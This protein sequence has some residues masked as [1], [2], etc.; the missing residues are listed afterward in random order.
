MLRY[1]LLLL[2]LATVSNAGWVSKKQFLSIIDYNTAV[3][4]VIAANPDKPEFI[5]FRRYTFGIFKQE[6]S[7]G[8]YSYS[9]E[10]EDQFYYIHQKE[11][12]FISREQY[13]KANRFSNG[14]R[15]IKA[16]YWGK[17]WKKKLYVEHGSLKLVTQASIGPNMFRVPTARFMIKHYS[18]TEYYDLLT[19]DKKLVNML[20]NDL[21]F[22]IYLTMMYLKYNYEIALSKGWSKPLKRAVGKH[23]GGWSNWSYVKKV[24]S[25]IQYTIKALEDNRYGIDLREYIKSR[26]QEMKK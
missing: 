21:E 12:I 1:I 26:K 7:Y 6:S 16:K 17:F 22:S 19:N 10:E 20:L 11:R 9:D 2:I 8:K 18:M 4:N 15:Y 3:D 13:D 23:N 24:E 14:E 5:K 25:G